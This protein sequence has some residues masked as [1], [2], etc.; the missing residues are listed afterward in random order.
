MFLCLSSGA[1]ER[2]RKDVILALA[3]PKG[4]RLQFRYSTQWVDP[5]VLQGIREKGHKKTKA[6]ICYIDQYDKSKVPKVIPC[7]YALVVDSEIHGTTVVV[8]FDLGDFAHAQDLASFNDEVRGHPGNKTPTVGQDGMIA[9]YY[10]ADMGDW[11]PQSIQMSAD[12]SMWEQVVTQISPRSDFSRETVFYVVEAIRSVSGHKKA[13]TK[14]GFFRLKPAST[15]EFEIYHFHPT[16]GVD[17]AFLRLQAF[18]ASVALTSNPRIT[19]DSRY[20]VKRMRFTTSRPTAPEM[21]VLSVYRGGESN[22][23]ET[24]EPDFDIHLRI[25]GTWG[26]KLIVGVLFG[27]VLAAPNVCAALCN[28][29][30]DPKAISAIIVVSAVA[31]IVA[32]LIA[33]FGLKSGT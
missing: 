25:A 16:S 13:G 30:L 11:Q 23:E 27:V 4:L 24:K 3:M 14:N 5:V 6:L 7:R 17:K 21:A 10:C 2:Y 18:G 26:R 20:D 29:G 28:T 32:G 31:G 19:M 22:I 9:G 1:R 33:A 15:Y 12:V 8:T